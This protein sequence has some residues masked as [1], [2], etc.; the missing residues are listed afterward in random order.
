MEGAKLKQPAEQPQVIYI[1]GCR[2]TIKYSRHENP[3][4]LQAI[5]DVLI[6]SISPEETWFFTFLLK[7][8][9]IMA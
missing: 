1:D 7:Y 2:V 6:N 3:P 9:I 8:K 5:R 4:A